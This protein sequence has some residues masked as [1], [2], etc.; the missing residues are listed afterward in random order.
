MVSFG[1][2]FSCDFNCVGV[3][4]AVPW[5][6]QGYISMAA[7]DSSCQAAHSCSWLAC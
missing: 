5:M 1:H 4:H 2:P 6:D 7:D 3:G